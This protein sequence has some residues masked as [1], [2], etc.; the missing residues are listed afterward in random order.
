MTW[1]LHLDLSLTSCVT[2]KVTPSLSQSQFFQSYMGWAGLGELWGF[3][4]F[5]KDLG[6]SSGG[7][8]RLT[9]G[10]HV[11]GVGTL[12]VSVH[13][14]I[15]SDYVLFVP[16]WWTFLCVWPH[17]IFECVLWSLFSVW[18]FMFLCFTYIQNIAHIMSLLLD[19]FLQTKH[20][21]ISCDQVKK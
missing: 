3:P 6:F 21:R 2:D 10:L 18:A 13:S 17:F 8:M 12:P 5:E 1:L 19:G 14:G 7:C 20:A 15:F 16:Y 4:L 9:C 11:L